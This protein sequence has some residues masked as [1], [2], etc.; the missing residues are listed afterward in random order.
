MFT[1]RA[2]ST[3]S[4]ALTNPRIMMLGKPAT[5]HVAMLDVAKTTIREANKAKIT[6]LH[7]RD[8]LSQIS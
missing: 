4:I 2:H 1:L 5:K 7:K 3:A 8:S 6:L